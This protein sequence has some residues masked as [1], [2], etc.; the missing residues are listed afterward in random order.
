[1]RADLALV[2]RLS[3]RNAMLRIT[4]HEE[5]DTREFNDDPKK[6]FVSESSGRALKQAR[7]RCGCSGDQR[8]SRPEARG[9]GNAQR[10]ECMGSGWRIRCWLLVF[11][12]PGDDHW[13]IESSDRRGR[14]DG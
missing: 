13:T 1:M 9:C 11:R 14:S 10:A 7:Q 5:A 6:K 8:S 2:M 4:I 3:W 12:S